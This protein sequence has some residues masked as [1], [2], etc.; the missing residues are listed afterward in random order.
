MPATLKEVE[1]AVVAVLA[2]C[3]LATTSVRDVLALSASRLACAEADVKAHKGRVK[4]IIVE[5]A[6][7]RAAAWVALRFFF[8]CF[9]FFFF[10]FAQLTFL[11]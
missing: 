4:E 8:F 2:G 9:F 11:F 1:A 10:F 3:D 7:R 6:T 5:E